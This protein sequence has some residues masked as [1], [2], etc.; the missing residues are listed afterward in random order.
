M[1]IG[2]LVAAKPTFFLWPLFLLLA[3]RRKIALRAAAVCATVS[4]LPALIYGRVIYEQWAAALKGDEHSLFPTE[5]SISGFFSRIAYP[6]LGML[7]A[8]A[9]AVFLAAWTVKVRE[10][11]AWAIGICASI[12]CA[13]LAWF[14]YAL[15]LAPAFISRPW[16][17]GASFAATLLFV[18]SFVPLLTA[19]SPKLT[20]LCGGSIYFSAIA[21][22]TVV[23]LRHGSHQA[24]KAHANPPEL[25]AAIGIENE[26]PRRRNCA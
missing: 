1:W 2:M 25:A 3:G 23:I 12:L 9:T 17:R 18:P 14:H 6:E 8:C 16:N 20:L 26:R 22:M 15:T 5:V 19:G 7:L 11:S 4:A 13:P 21:I 10:E 24:R